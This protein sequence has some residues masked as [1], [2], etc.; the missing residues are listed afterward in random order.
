MKEIECTMIKSAYRLY[1]SFL[2]CYVT[3]RDFHEIPLLI[4]HLISLILSLMIPHKHQ[5]G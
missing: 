4:I 3:L 5:L 1:G 2:T